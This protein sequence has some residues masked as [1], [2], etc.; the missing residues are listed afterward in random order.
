MNNL[1]VI[2]ISTWSFGKT[3]SYYCN[4]SSFGCEGNEMFLAKFILKIKFDKILCLNN[5]NW[6]DPSSSR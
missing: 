6:I 2:D 3:R 1:V 4:I 5:C